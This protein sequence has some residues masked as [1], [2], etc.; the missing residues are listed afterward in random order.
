M[1]HNY[2]ADDHTLSVTPE[3]NALEFTRILGGVYLLL[4][5]L[6]YRQTP[7]NRWTGLKLNALVNKA[8]MYIL[9][10]QFLNYTDYNIVEV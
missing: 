9:Q 3:A 1:C 6:W 2:M 10:F 5:A 4:L 7:R 8:I